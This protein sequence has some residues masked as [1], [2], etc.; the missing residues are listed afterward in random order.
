M[1]VDDIGADDAVGADVV[2]GAE[3][4]PEF[5]ADLIATLADLEGDDFRRHGHLFVLRARSFFL[6]EFSR[7]RYSL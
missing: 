1:T 7:F 5:H 2:L 4:L 3:S 6:N